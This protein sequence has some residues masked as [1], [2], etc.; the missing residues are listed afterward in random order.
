M[1][2]QYSGFPLIVKALSGS[3]GKG[4]ILSEKHDNFRDL[5]ELIHVTNSNANR[6]LQELCSA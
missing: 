4:I 6:I 5:M 2:E 3:M 1:V